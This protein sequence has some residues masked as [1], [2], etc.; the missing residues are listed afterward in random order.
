MCTA[1]ATTTSFQTKYKVIEKIGEGSFSEVLKCQNRLNG[2]LYAAKRLKKT[3]QNMNEVLENTELIATRKIPRHPNV[4]HLIES[5]SD[6]LP[7]RITL[8]FELMD[9][10]LY[11]FMRGRKG[12]AILETRVKC[13]VC[14]L[15]EG[16]V[17]LHSYGIFHRDVKPENILLRGSCLKI[18]DLG[19]IRVTRSRPPYTEYIST[20]WY[21]SPECLLTSGYYGPKMDVWAA[22]C[23]FYELLTLEPLFPGENELDQIGKIHAV[24]GTPNSRVIAKFRRNS[25]ARSGDIYFPQQSGQGQGLAC[26]L[27]RIS[28]AGL[29]VLQ[30]MLTY[31]PEDRP[32]SAKML[33]HPY[34]G[35]VR[36]RE[37]T[38]MKTR[39][40]RK[41]HL[42]SVPGEQRWPSSSMT[43][44]HWP[45]NE[46]WQQ[47]GMRT[48]AEECRQSAASGPIESMLGNRYPQRPYR[49]GF[50]QYRS[51]R[52]DQL[53]L[54]TSSNN[55]ARLVGLRYTQVGRH[56]LRK[57]HNASSSGQRNPK[58]K[59]SDRY[60]FQ[61]ARYRDDFSTIDESPRP[62]PAT[63]YARTKELDFPRQNCQRVESL[64]SSVSG[65]FS[66]K[67]KRANNLMLKTPQS[68]RSV[69]VS[70]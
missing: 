45:A 35:D 34:F 44:F 15:L 63:F 65:L 48:N 26:A 33:E 16:L 41:P 5:F 69:H 14:Q 23:V 38:N 70:F 9:M 20:R 3:Y 53:K 47:V 54:L 6:S 24:L 10:S 62:L 2:T 25:R 64:N 21:R 50:P 36:S 32:V 13:Y 7:G 18:G 4:L 52:S 58:T 42:L 46:I 51:R 29:E 17:H 67:D 22:G 31:D 55:D 11:D 30:L 27:P 68:L 28:A 59:A 49:S 39:Q 61:D 12:R 57:R 40:P 37:M 8:I 1:R 56:L 60:C 43:A 19:S 66:R